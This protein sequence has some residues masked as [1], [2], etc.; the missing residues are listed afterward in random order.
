MTTNNRPRLQ[1]ILD[2]P[3]PLLISLYAL[4]L[5]S[6]MS[7]MEIF[8]WSACAFTLLYIFSNHFLHMR[9]FYFFRL[10]VELPLIGLIFIVWLGLAVNAP[11]V[12]KLEH[13]GSLR[14]IIMLYLF[15]YAFELFPSLNR[16]LNIFLVGSTIVGIYAIFQHFTCIDLVRPD[17]PLSPAPVDGATT[18]QSIGFLSHHLTYGYS[19]G[20][21]ICFAFAGL[22]LGKR[23][24]VLHRMG[25]FISTVIIGASLVWTYGRGV[26]IAV[27]LS[28]FVMAAYV[29][30][31]HFFSFVLIAGLIF[32]VAYTSNPEL[33][34]RFNSI[35]SDQHFSNVERQGLWKANFE[36][37]KDHPWLGVGYGQNLPRLQE[38]YQKVNVQ[39]EWGGHAHNNYL[40]MLSTTGILGF[41][42]YML[43]VLTFLLMTHRLWLDIPETHF[44]HRVI[45]LGALGAQICLH[46]GGVTQWNFGDAEVNHLFIFILAMVAFLAEKYA[47]GIV[48][49]DYAL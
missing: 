31:K 15:T 21:L 24:S 4:S 36:M 17:R 20:L 34:E 2:T 14:W 10:G 30:K 19:A 48:P 45:V 7:G 40:Q 5:M 37:F 13:V 6:S 39:R 28:F 46:T 44:W 1:A 25:F 27:G 9:E 8:G 35:W 33:K 3:I 42:C 23:K 22:L 11:G 12:E 47:R 16:I 43:F 38:Y 41:F 29:S 32:G 49:D 18:C 26:W